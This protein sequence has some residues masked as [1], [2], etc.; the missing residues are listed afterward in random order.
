MCEFKGDS[1]QLTVHFS[2]THIRA[3]SLAISDEKSLDLVRDT[4]GKF[5]CPLCRQFEAVD[6]RVIQ[7]SRTLVPT[8]TDV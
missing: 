4:D 6:S 8:F 1:K 5:T 2:R 7:V 3:L